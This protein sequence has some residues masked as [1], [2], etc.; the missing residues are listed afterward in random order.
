M[1]TGRRPI[2]SASMLKSSE[3]II[4]PMSVVLATRPAALAMP[5]SPNSAGATKPHDW[6][7]KPSMIRHR[8]HRMNT[9]TWNDRTSLLSIVSVMLMELLATLS[10]PSG[11]PPDARAG[12]ERVVALDH[13]HGFA[14]T[15]FGGLEPELP[16][17]RASFGR[18]P[19]AI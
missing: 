11:V 3:P 16:R 8:P 5:H 12:G 1:R 7:S 4:T 15:V 18:Q 14:K 10:P 2:L 6:T 13:L 17:L 19:V 9:P